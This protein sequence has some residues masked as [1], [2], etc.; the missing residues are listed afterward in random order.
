MTWTSCGAGWRP[1]ARTGRERVLLTMSACPCW[2]LDP[3]VRVT[4][5]W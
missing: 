3:P 1:E 2:D 4:L 5:A